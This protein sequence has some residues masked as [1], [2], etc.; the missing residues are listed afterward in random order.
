M[1]KSPFFPRSARQIWCHF[2]IISVEIH[3]WLAIESTSQLAV[4]QSEMR[5]IF[6]IHNKTIL[7][8][9]YM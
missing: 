2:A 5:G 6:L 7:S 8:E 4:S 9:N 1:K 3:I